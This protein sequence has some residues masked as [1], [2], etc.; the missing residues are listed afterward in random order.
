MII[1]FTKHYVTKFSTSN[2]TQ[3]CPVCSYIRMAHFQ[4]QRNKKFHSPFV[5][6]APCLVNRL[7]GHSEKCD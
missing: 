6:K 5:A 1:I 2:L 4:W 3:F 7:L